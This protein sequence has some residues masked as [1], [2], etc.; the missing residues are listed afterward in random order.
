MQL[1]AE[2]IETALQPLQDRISSLEST[3]ARL[4]EE[5]AAMAATQAHFIENQEIQARLIRE[6]KEKARKE[7]GKTEL[8]RA[9][10]IEKYLAARPDHKATFETLR[11]DLGIDKDLLND[12]IKTLMSSSP[13]RY[14]IARAPGDKR[15]RAL[16][17]LP[18]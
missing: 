16:I 10:K 9:E 8:S 18:K 15:K 7:P 12:A 17:M 3:I 1:L 4:M 11:G 6:L 2:P 14:G 5:N 13:G